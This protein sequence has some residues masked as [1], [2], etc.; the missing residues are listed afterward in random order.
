PRCLRQTATRRPGNVFPALVQPRTVH[1][2]N[3]LG[4]LAVSARLARLS[5]GIYSAL[6]RRLAND[7]LLW[8]ARAELYRVV[9]SGI[10]QRSPWLF[11]A[12][13]VRRIGVHALVADQRR[14][15]SGIGGGSFLTC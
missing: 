14:E 15:S 13:V 10:L 11:A 5:L 6:Y 3:F 2:G 4:A 9:F 7:Q 8:L 12:G 1:G